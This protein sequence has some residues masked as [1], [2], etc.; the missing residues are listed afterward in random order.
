MPELQWDELDFLEC[1]EVEP[2]IEDEYKTRYVYKVA[3]AGLILTVVVRSLESYLWLSLQQKE[4]ELPLVEFAL[5]VHG[6]IRYIKDKRGEYL[7]LTDCLLAP[8]RTS[9]LKAETIWDVTQP[10]WT[11]EISIKPHIQIRYLD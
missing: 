9:Y 8:R 3:R 5:F 2:Q 11:L 1:L 7:E 4:S 10:T 6:N